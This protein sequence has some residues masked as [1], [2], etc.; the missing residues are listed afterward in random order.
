MKPRRV[1]LVTGMPGCGKE[2]F[3]KVAQQENLPVV[4]MGDIVR[5]EARARG[6]EPTDAAVGGL[7][8]EE[9]RKHGYG[10][11]AERTI[12]RISGEV[13]VIDGV[14]GR[15]E[16][17][18]FERAFGKNLVVVAVHAS[19][20]TR[21]ERIRNRH[22]SDDILTQEEFDLREKREL[23]W[24]LGDVIASADYMIVNEDGIEDF[25]EKAR[26]VLARILG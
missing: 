25:R 16:V 26:E 21:F 9:R 17:E 19:P 14:R 24:G 3:V 10:V 18:V 4:R 20:F 1:I 13:A 6:L 2:E 22:R 11:W 8:N 15:G 7:A 12:P 5:E 23:G